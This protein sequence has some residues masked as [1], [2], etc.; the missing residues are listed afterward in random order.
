MVVSAQFQVV[1]LLNV[2]MH[3]QFFQVSSLATIGAEQCKSWTQSMYI[4]GIMCVCSLISEPRTKTLDETDE[5]YK[6][7]LRRAD[8][9]GL[10]KALILR[11][12]YEI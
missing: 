5:T 8:L 9:F 4:S 2:A 7:S 10:A 3:I 12:S 11:D 1:M 6:Y